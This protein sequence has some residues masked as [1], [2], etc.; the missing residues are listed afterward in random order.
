VPRESHLRTWIPAWALAG[1]AVL[2]LFAVYTAWQSMAAERE[3]QDLQSRAAEEQQRDHQLQAERLPYLAGLKIVAASDTTKFY[4]ASKNPTWPPVT[5]Y[6]NGKMGLVLAA[7][8][9]PAVADGRTLELWMLPRNAKPIALA[10]FRPDANGR[11]FLVLP[12]QEQLAAA[13]ALM[14]DEEPAAG[15]R[16]PTSPSEWIA[17]IR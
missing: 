12:L 1:A 15:S 8:N 5:A 2:V 11:V 16:Q 3:I 17:L 9:L 7:E 6:W 10:V 13:E 14:I 4:L